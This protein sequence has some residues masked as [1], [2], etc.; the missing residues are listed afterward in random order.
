MRHT[1]LPDL[2]NDDSITYAKGLVDRCL[3]K[4][5]TVGEIKAADRVCILYTMYIP[6][7]FY[8]IL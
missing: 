1:E 4:K 6:F 5:F 7:I 2:L 8:N 3:I